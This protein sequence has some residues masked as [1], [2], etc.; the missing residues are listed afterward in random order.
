M[1]NSLLNI[2]NLSTQT[3]LTPLNT[4]ELMEIQGGVGPIQDAVS[5]FTHC[6][7]YHTFESFYHCI[8]SH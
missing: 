2:H 1:K 7:I 8:N 6:L 4:E 5:I 3:S